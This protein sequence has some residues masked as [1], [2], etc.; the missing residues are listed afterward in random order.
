MTPAI[1]L[2]SKTPKT[3]KITIPKK[4][5][6]TTNPQLDRNILGKPHYP[7]LQQSMM[8][9]QKFTSIQSLIVF[10]TWKANQSFTV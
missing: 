8:V 10:N 9:S 6:K 2:S 5:G 4:P 3:H 7:Q 1:Y